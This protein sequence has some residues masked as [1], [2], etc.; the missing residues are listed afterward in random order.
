MIDLNELE[1][2]QLVLLHYPEHAIECGTVMNLRAFNLLKKMIGDCDL[3]K[4]QKRQG[5]YY[6]IRYSDLASHELYDEY[7]AEMKIAVALMNKFAV[8]AKMRLLSTI[9]E[10]PSRWETQKTLKDDRPGE[11]DDATI[12]YGVDGANGNPEFDS[13]AMHM[14]LE[15]IE[16]VSYNR[17]SQGKHVEIQFM[18]YANEDHEYWLSLIGD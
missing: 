12:P 1:E 10:L 18:D 6:R 7:C 9:A 14:L 8:E 4:N 2:D 3:E 15:K 13:A 5:N 11:L 16:D 17:D